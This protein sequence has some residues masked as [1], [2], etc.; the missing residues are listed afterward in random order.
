MLVWRVD[1]KNLQAGASNHYVQQGR[2]GFIKSK[3]FGIQPFTWKFHE[4][5]ITFTHA[6][7]VFD[8]VLANASATYVNIA[9]QEHGK[10]R[11]PN[12]VRE[13]VYRCAE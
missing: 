11:G 6:N 3:A 7:G 4:E 1:S 12:P 5:Y 10:Q 2:T 8:L 13:K 9:R